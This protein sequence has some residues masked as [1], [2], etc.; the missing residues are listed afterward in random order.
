MSRRAP[1]P[2]RRA[3]DARLRR[4]EGGESPSCRSERCA[5]SADAFRLGEWRVTHGAARLWRPAA[6]PSA[7]AS[8]PL[9][10]LEPDAELELKVL[11]V[12][13]QPALL[14]AYLYLR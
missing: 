8:L 9:L 2:A 6:P 4:W 11:F 10:L 7:P 12:P 14:S 3:A 1:P 5:Y 13:P